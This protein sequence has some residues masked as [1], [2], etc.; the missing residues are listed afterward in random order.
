M[1]W[2]LAQINIARLRAPIDDPLVAEFVA[3]LEPVNRLADESAGFVW[4]LQT[5]DGNATAVRPYA[6]ELIIVNM[7]VW[8]SLEHLADFVYRSAHTE[9]L[10]GKRAWFER[11]ADAHAALWWIAAGTEPSVEEGAAR[12]EMLR[13]RGPSTDAFTFGHPFAAPGTVEVDVDDRNTCPA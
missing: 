6:D 12:L 9:F 4:R 1:D 8:D 7:S 5:E 3:G 10:R 11:M 2:H 13:S